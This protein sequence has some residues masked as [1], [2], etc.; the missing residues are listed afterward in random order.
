MI[1]W[2]MPRAAELCAV[3]GRAVEALHRVRR[4]AQRRERLEERHEVDVARHAAPVAAPARVPRGAPARAA[5]A[6]RGDP[7]RSRSRGRARPRGRCAGARAR[8]SASVR[9]HLPGLAARARRRGGP[10]SS[11]AKNRPSRNTSW[12]SEGSASRGLPA[13]PS[14]SSTAARW[15]AWCSRTSRETKRSPKARTARSSGATAL[16]ADARAAVRL[17]ALAQQRE[18]RGEPLRRLVAAELARPRE[19]V[20]LAQRALEAKR[21]GVELQPVHLARAAPL[22]ALAQLGVARPARARVIC[23][24]ARETGTS[25]V[26]GIR[27]SISSG[28]AAPVALQH[29]APVEPQRLGGDEGRDVGVAVAIAADP[30]AEPQQGALGRALDAVDGAGR[31]AEV[32]AHPG[33]RGEEHRL[34][35]VEQVQHLVDR[36]RRAVLEEAR[37]PERRHLGGQ[38]LGRA[39]R[40]P[41]IRAQALEQRVHALEQARAPSSASSPSGAR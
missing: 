23:A 9:E 12:R 35:G 26:D 22:G 31:G 29:R 21:D 2:C 11:E 19:G 7:G 17:E 25:A 3:G 20:G 5:R 6:R 1:C 28:I 15:R 32:R 39:A 8:R 34:E 36:R 14:S 18:I 4:R 33:H 38:L 24:S 10:A 37:L 30:R 27:R 40:R 16:G 41:G 13:R